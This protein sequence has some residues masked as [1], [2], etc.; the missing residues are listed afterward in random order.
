MGAGH[1]HGSAPASAG[2]G[3]TDWF[4][5]LRE[6]EN[7]LDLRIAAIFIIFACSLLGSVPPIFIKRTTQ[8]ALGGIVR[9][10]SAGVI[11]ALALVHV[12]PHAAVDMAELTPFPV[13]GTCTVFG[14]L[15]LVAIEHGLNTM[16]SHK[17]NHGHEHAEREKDAD[18]EMDPHT[19]ACL[20]QHNST[21]G[22]LKSAEDAGSL[23]QQVCGCI[24]IATLQSYLVLEPM[25]CNILEQTPSLSLLDARSAATSLSLPYSFYS[26]FQAVVLLCCRCS[27][28]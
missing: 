15:L 12:Y 20:N 13:A 22:W 11:L 5:L 16:L 19:H 2:E 26:M 23:R 8:S 6:P 24:V 9:A 21:V 4:E 28:T 25:R 1:K 17:H 7:T 14:V 10:F 18:I 3:P 27:L